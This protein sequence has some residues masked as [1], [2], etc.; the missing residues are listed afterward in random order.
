[1]VWWGRNAIKV[2]INY[3]ITVENPEDYLGPRGE[4]LLSDEYIYLVCFF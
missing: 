2:R 4:E 1:M 3:L